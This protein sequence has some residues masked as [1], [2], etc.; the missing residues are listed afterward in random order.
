MG[1]ALTLLSDFLQEY[2]AALQWLNRHGVRT[3]GTRLAAYRRI[4]A[5]A[6]AEEAR[7]RFEHQEQPEMIN[8]IVEA[9]EIVEIAQIDDAHL[10]GDDVLDKLRKISGGPAE[11]APDGA[12]PARDYAFEF[13]TAAVLEQQSQFGGFSPLGGDLTVGEDQFP[14]ECKRVSSLNSLRN[15][16]RG[17]RDKLRELRDAGSPPG[18]IAIDLTRPV[19]SAHG[20]I[21]AVDDGEFMR[22]AEQRLIAYL[23]GHV[24]TEQNIDT[25]ASESVLG[26]IARCRSAGVSGERSNV[27]RSVVWQ[28]CSIHADDSAED[29]IFRRIAGAFGPGELRDGTRE[30]IVDAKVRIAIKQ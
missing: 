24:M 13:H 4:I 29:E 3:E 26:V 20:P 19:K 8:A 6:E 14:T 22:E 9:S 11:M 5:R 18:V 17:G 21:L 2:D 27:R 30:E 7:G 12:D 25:L 15:R 1:T 16:L 10:A 28:A 23:A